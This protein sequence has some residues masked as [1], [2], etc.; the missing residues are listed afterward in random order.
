MILKNKLQNMFILDGI[1]IK[2]ID[3]II[4]FVLLCKMI[5]NLYFDCSAYYMPFLGDFFTQIIQFLFSIYLNSASIYLI[6]CPL[7]F[8]ASFSNLLTVTPDFNFQLFLS[9]NVS[10]FSLLLSFEL[11]STDLKISAD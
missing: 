1:I 7:R 8:A 9:S 3:K 6:L 10:R 5:I 2:N 11:S 4:L